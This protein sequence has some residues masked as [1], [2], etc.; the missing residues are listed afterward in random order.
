MIP[1]LVKV[2]FSWGR[3]DVRGKVARGGFFFSSFFLFS[4]DAGDD[5]V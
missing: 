2:A 1:S 4:R 3:C 5:A